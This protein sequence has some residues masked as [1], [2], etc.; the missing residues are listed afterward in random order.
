MKCP[1]CDFDNPADT[2]YCGKC[3]TRLEQEGPIGP[4]GPTEEVSPSLTKTLETPK[5]ELTTGSTFADRYQ[6]IE[7]LGKGG[8]GKIYKVI[9]KDIEE[10]VALKLIKPDIAADKKTIKRFGNELKFARK[11]S[12]KNV[13]RMYDLGKYEGTQFITMEYV[14]GEDL[15]SMIRMMGQ[16]SAGK[17]IAIAKQVCEGLAEAHRLG[18]VHRDLKPQNLMIDKEG[19]TRIMDFGIARSLKA[20]GITGAGVMIGTPEYMSPEQVEGKEADQRSDI[21]SLGVILYEMVTGRVP[22]EGDTPFIIGVKHK[23]EIPKDPKEL[24]TQVPSDLNRVIMR[25]LEKEKEKRYQSAGEVHSELD[26]IEKGIPT[27]ERVIP[28]KK[29]LT[30]KEI[31]VTFKKPWIIIAALFVVVVVAGIAI[32]YLRKE[33]PVAPSPKKNMLVVLPFENLGLPEDEYFADGITEEITSRLAALHGLG[34]ISRSSAIRYKKTHTA[35]KQ[36]GEELGVDFVLEGT[37]RWDRSP[38]GKGRVRVTPQLIRVSDDT[39]LWSDRYDREMEDIFAVQSDIAEQVIRQLDITLLEP[40]RR[41]LKAKPTENL[42]A[43]QA[44]LKGINYVRGVY[45]LEENLRLA[46]QMFER[47]VELDPNFALAFAGLSEARSRLIHYGYDLT[48]ECKAKAKMAADRS[49]ELQPELPEGHLALGRYYYDCHREYD[50]ALEELAIAEKNLPNDSEIP[51]VIG[52]VR[53]RQGNFEEAISY[54]KKAFEL[55]PQNANIAFE[56]GF[57]YQT[58]RRYSEAEQYADRAISIAPDRTGAYRVKA[59]NYWLWQGSMEKAR[60]T[61]EQM[62]KEVDPFA[63]GTLITQE[64][65]ERDYQAALELLSSEFIEYYEGEK[66]VRTGG[67]YQLLNEPELARRSFDSASTLLEKRIREFP[68]NHDFHS[69]LGMAYA[70]LGRKEEAIREGKRAV[71]LYPVSK[72]ALWGPNYVLFLAEIYVMVGEYDAALEQIE[73]LL[74][75]PCDLSVPL[76]RLDPKWDPLREH[77]RFKRL[78]EENSFDDS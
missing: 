18:I 54:F 77:P 57:T 66:A 7:E 12:H 28:K 60:A 2:L 13:C 67:I 47:A 51:F 35:I 48:E 31:T 61:L 19:D 26:R 1:K 29:P 62:P 22:F 8:M 9:D 40:E 11:I 25:C 36:I 33:K 58:L 30:S 17:T 20:K 65:Y 42:D 38:E 70:G 75:I 24:N 6:I 21:Y 44:Y 23:S 15:K 39:H 69:F 3:G 45:Y 4:S 55:S 53:R 49:L 5:E 43:Y 52:A 74:S 63:I 76:L 50:K 14:E 46:V 16:L 41:A 37:V 68:D 59:R 56:I 64:L 27:T 72:D 32:L 71:E 73:Y 78:L 10:K 34:V